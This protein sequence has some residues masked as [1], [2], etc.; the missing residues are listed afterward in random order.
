MSMTRRR[1]VAA[2]SA[3]VALLFATNLAVGTGTAGATVQTPPTPA[4]LPLGIEGLAHYVGQVAC[5]PHPRPGTLA[6]ANLLVHTYPG[7]SYATVYRC[8][9][10]GTRSEHYDGRAIDWMA[11]AR[12]PSQAAAATAAINWMLATDSHGNR[13][14]MARRL[15]IMYIIFNNRMWGAWNGQ[16]APYNN[17]AKTPSTAYDSYCHRNHVHISLGW[18]GAYERTSFFSKRVFDA[19][20]YGPCKLSTTTI[21]RYTGFR[22]YPCP[23]QH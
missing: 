13:F 21:L 22:R 1:L 14:A 19:T 10:D 2:I 23:G 7:T 8:G 3:L 16:W 9:T 4:G 15:G 6:L 18:N 12:I 17:C 11:S 20:D 5:D